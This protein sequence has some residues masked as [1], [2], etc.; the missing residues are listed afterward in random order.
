MREGKVGKM[1]GG[2]HHSGWEANICL[3]GTPGK[4]LRP[5]RGKRSSNTKES[6]QL[7]S[8]QEKGKGIFLYKERGF[9][10]PWRGNREKK[11]KVAW[12]LALFRRSKNGRGDKKKVED[13]AKRTVST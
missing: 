12:E 2:S 8:R 9:R 4:V 1:G 6:N 11:R 7:G 5:F 3:E 13:L 10:D